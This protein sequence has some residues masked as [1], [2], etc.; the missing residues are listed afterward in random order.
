MDLVGL[1]V[2]EASLKSTNQSLGNPPPWSPQTAWDIP[3]EIAERKMCEDLK[4]GLTNSRRHR[5]Y[6]MT[7]GQ[8]RRCPA[9]VG[10]PC[11]LFTARRRPKLKPALR[12]I[13][14]QQWHI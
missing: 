5:E 10:V 9:S 13:C 1:Q 12:L 11:E 7:A 6:S 14:T 3:E 2:A 8:S 4:R